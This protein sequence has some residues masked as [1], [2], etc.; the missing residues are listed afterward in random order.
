MLPTGL[1]NPLYL[2]LSFEGVL[3]ERSEITACFDVLSFLRVR[4]RVGACG[5]GGSR[6]GRKSFARLHAIF[7]PITDGWK[8][9]LLPGCC[10]TSATIC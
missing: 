2:L 10:L 7:E 9:N 8:T 1:K 3:G 6:G 4:W 5:T